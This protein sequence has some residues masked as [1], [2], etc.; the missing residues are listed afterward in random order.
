MNNISGTIFGYDPGGKAANGLAVL[1]V[2]DSRPK[3]LAA[4]TLP[5]SE[6]VINEILSEDVIGLGADT[7]SCW[8]TGTGGWRPADLWLRKRY[9]AVIHSVMPPNMLS[10]SMVLNGMAVLIEAA[11]HFPNIKLCETH[12]KVLYYA[13]SHNKHNYKGS[14]AEMVDFLSRALDGLS[15]RT[16]NEHEWDAAISAYATLKGITGVWQNDLHEL[17]PE[18]N[19][20]IISPCGKTSYFWPDVE[21]VIGPPGPGA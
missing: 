11:K 14:R 5:D 19:F 15:V 21:Y 20:R 3:S 9:P 18:K 12:P 6:S 7:L 16:S 17:E 4:R 10:G 2:A 1:R 8:A 13:L